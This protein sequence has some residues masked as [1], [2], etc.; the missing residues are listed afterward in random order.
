MTVLSNIDFAIQASKDLGAELQDFSQTKLEKLKSI[1]IPTRKTE[2]WKYSAKRLKL[3]ETYP[4]SSSTNTVNEIDNGYELDCHVIIFNNTQ[5]SLNELGETGMTIKPFSDLN[6]AQSLQVVSGAIAQSNSYEFAIANSAYLQNGIYI[7]VAK[8]THINKP[9]KLVF[10]QTGEGVNFPRVFF[11]IESGS[12]ITIIE[13]IHIQANNSPST[14]VNSVCDINIEANAKA[15]YLRMN[16][17]DGKSKH[18]GATGVNLHRD[19][20]FESYHLALG[21]ELARH[22][23]LVKMLGSGAECQ[24]N[25]VCITQDKQHYANHTVVEHIAPNCTSDETYRCIA[26]NEA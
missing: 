2:S 5:L 20:R 23:L 15:Q 3:T 7:N 14:L 24:L 22:D 11:N 10:L 8:N 6:E 13:E 25:G 17:D 12:S 1:R 21:S 26:D 4:Q 19:A 16:F 9:V 18:V